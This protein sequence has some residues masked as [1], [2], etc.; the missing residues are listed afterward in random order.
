VDT[1]K[2]HKQWYQY[3]KYLIQNPEKVEVL[4]NNLY[5]TVKN[6]YSTDTVSD[7]RRELYMSKL[8]EKVE[9]VVENV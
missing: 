4:A 6:T 2:N 3:I 1:N 9:T 8:L 7:I 5:E